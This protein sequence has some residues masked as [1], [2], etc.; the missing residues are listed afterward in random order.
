MLCRGDAIMLLVLRYAQAADREI[1]LG[2]TPRVLF[3]APSRQI[4][5]NLCSARAPNTAREA[6]ALPGGT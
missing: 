5:A 4:A 1:G 2:S 6:R 3:V